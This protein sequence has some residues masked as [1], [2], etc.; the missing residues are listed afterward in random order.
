LWTEFDFC[1]HLLLRHL[2]FGLPKADNKDGGLSDSGKSG[3]RGQMPVL[4]GPD[5]WF[6]E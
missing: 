2:L 5:T 4:F 3:K 6:P 1:N